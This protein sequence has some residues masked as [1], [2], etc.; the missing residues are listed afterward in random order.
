MGP[1]FSEGFLLLF[2][3]LGDLAEARRPHRK[4]CI[5]LG[6]EVLRDRLTSNHKKDS[7]AA[8]TLL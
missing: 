8:C 4:S 7:E 1:P 3:F 6:I 2:K 5:I